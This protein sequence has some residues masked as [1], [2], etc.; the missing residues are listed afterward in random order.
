MHAKDR[1]KTKYRNAVAPKNDKYVY[2]ALA[3]GIFPFEKFI[4]FLCVLYIFVFEYLW[5]SSWVGG[6]GGGVA[7]Q[8]YYKYWGSKCGAAQHSPN[9]F[10]EA[11]TMAP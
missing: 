2:F 7:C 10:Y 1:I 4:A 6:D 8:W 3:L 9:T 5:L 11:A